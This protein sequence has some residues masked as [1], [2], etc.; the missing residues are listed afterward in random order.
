MENNMKDKLLNYYKDHLFHCILPFWMDRSIDKEDGGYYNCF[1]NKTGELHSTDK[2]TWSQGRF[3]WVLSKLA[4]ID[5][6]YLDGSKRELY[7]EQADQGATF[8]LQHCIMDDGKCAFLVN[9]SGEPQEIRPGSGY[10]VSIYAD[11][12]VTMGLARYA[13]VTENGYILDRAVELHDSIVRRIEQGNIRTEPY[14]IPAGYKMH[15]IPMI[16]L[17]T[18]QETA[19]ALKVAGDKR[20]AGIQSQNGVFVREIMDDFV[21]DEYVLEMVDENG[22]PVDTILGTFVNPGHTIEDMWF[23]MHHAVEQNDHHLIE[24]AARLAHKALSI[25]WDQEYDGIFQYTHKN[26]GP[27]RGSKRGLENEDMV[28]KVEKN[29]DNKLWWPHTEALYTFLLAYNLTGNADYLQDHDKVFDY[30]FS[31]FPNPDKEIGEWISIRDRVGRPDT[32]V[33][34][35][36]VKDPYH[37]PRNLLQIIELLS[38]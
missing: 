36:P 6:N 31:T 13:S 25:G 1:D 23:I 18:G 30:T 11:C 9:K 24:K 3:L 7:I 26:G 27:P 16:A 29:W 8:I 2:F 4:E 34:A 19:S 33:T 5:K 12:F 17:N 15:G 21:H 37:T 32:R 14:P 35:L 22:V 28:D 20:A 38:A 10:D